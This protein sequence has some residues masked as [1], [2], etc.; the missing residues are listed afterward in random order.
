MS[1]VSLLQRVRLRGERYMY[2][3]VMPQHFLPGEETH[4]FA[5]PCPSGLLR[6]CGALINTAPVRIA[7]NHLEEGGLLRLL[8]APKSP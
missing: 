3:C 7:P 2:V 6:H 1:G 8:Q 5:P 4:V